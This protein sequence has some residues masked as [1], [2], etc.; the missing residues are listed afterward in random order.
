MVF[1]FMD[2][3]GPRGSWGEGSVGVRR[4]GEG[5]DAERGEEWVGRVGM[6]E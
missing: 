1:P 2:V 6:N 4:G 5:L 3:A